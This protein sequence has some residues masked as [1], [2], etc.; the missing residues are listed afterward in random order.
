MACQT[1][2]CAHCDEVH[3][4]PPPAGVLAPLLVTVHLI[5]EHARVVPDAF[6]VHESVG[7]EV[8]VPVLAHLLR[9]P[10][11]IQVRG[12]AKLRL[13]IEGTHCSGN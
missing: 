3:L 6:P 12:P 1:L 2:G 5:L 9:L 11:I 4:E 7:I 13:H 10:L 8:V